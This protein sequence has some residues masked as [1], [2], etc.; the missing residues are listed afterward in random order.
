MRRNAI[1]SGTPSPQLHN[2][3]SQD[4]RVLALEQRVRELTALLEVN[5]VLNTDLH[6]ERVLTVV[7]EQAVKVLEAERGTLWLLEPHSETIAAHV[8]VGAGASQVNAIRMARGEGIVGRVIESGMGDLVS[9]AQTDARWASRV[10]AAT[11]LVTRSI[12]TAPLVAH[13]GAIGCLQL[14]NKCDGQ[15]F[16]E[17]DLDLLSALGAQAALV[18][19][20]SRL[21]DQATKLARDLENAWRGSLEALAAAMAARDNETQQHCYRTVELALV[22]ARRLG[23]PDADLPALARGALLHDIGKIG[24]PDGILYKPGPL[25]EE[26]RDTMKQHVRMGHDML[27][28]IPFFQDALPIVLYHHENYDGSGY[29]SGNS[30]EEIPLAAR[31]FH[32][33][34]VYDALISER[35]Y[36]PAWPHAQAIKELKKQI[37]SGFD[38]KVIAALDMLTPEEVE[39]IRNTRGF[40]PGT[41]GLI[42]RGTLSD[43]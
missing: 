42:G 3:S 11:G 39:F 9:D 21:L 23:V 28:S 35:P 36:K 8:S 30:G 16:H 10:D 24:V 41:H 29:L 25:T 27:R 17:N 22:L 2:E 15:Y 38:P 26:E 18:I 4:G 1:N 31:I 19:Q 20:N 13:D 33:V 43:S 6:L 32:V 5:R 37:G 12:V 7:L 40:S 34:D 14:I